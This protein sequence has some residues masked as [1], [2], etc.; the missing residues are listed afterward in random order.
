MLLWWYCPRAGLKIACGLNAKS[1]PALAVAG[2][3]V[4]PSVQ[5]PTDLS[6]VPSPNRLSAELG[7]ELPLGSG[8]GVA[9][10]TG[11]SM[12]ATRVSMRIDVRSLDQSRSSSQNFTQPSP[13]KPKSKAVVE[14]IPLDAYPTTR[15]HSAAVC[16]SAAARG[17]Y[18]RSRAAIV[19]AIFATATFVQG[20]DACARGSPPPQP[21]PPVHESSQLYV[22]AVAM[23]TAVSSLA[24][25][26][27]RNCTRV[28]SASVA[29]SVL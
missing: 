29:R 20:E 7:C 8:Q 19:F 15:S 9:C 11:S 10:V 5:S 14:L 12:L 1:V 2:Q 6:Y 21:A 3:I 4:T 26:Q 24:S 22:L 25:A 13:V 27:S 16:V 17:K 28:L 23:A 18:A